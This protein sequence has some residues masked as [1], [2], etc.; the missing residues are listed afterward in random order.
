MS[1]LRSQPARA[2]TSSV[3]GVPL[4]ARAA[5]PRAR[6]LATVPNPQHPTDGPKPS[7]VPTPPGGSGNT[8]LWL[9]GGTGVAVGAWYYTREGEDP[10]A[11]RKADEAQM[12]QKVNELADAGKRTAHSTVREGEKGYQDIKASGADKVAQA[13]KEADDAGASVVK[14]YDA[15][16]ASAASTYNAAAGKVEGAAHDAAQKAEKTYAEAAETTQSWGAWFG[17]WF[18]YG[19]GKAE[20]AKREGAAKVADGAGEVKKEAEKRT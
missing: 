16:K 4:I 12:R 3:R 18:G 10:H 6:T 7:D 2:F 8:L 19:K 5:Y 20:D 14:Q 11:R 15:A 13:R 9:V 17:S 1:P